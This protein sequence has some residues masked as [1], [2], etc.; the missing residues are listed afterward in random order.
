M[1]HQPRNVSVVEHPLVEHKLGLMRRK[2][3]STAE[4]FSCCARSRF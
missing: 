4:F 3:T 2:E 1:S